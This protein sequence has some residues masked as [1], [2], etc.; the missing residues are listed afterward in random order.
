MG[1]IIAA[2]VLVAIAWAVAVRYEIA[3]PGGIRNQPARWTRFRSP[4]KG[5]PPDDAEPL[6][7]DDGG[8]LSYPGMRPDHPAVLLAG[9]ALLRVHPSEAPL[10]SWATGPGLGRPLDDVLA[11]A[12]AAPVSQRSAVLALGTGAAPGWLAEMLRN[13]GRRAAVPMVAAQAR[14]IVAG[15]SAHVG[16]GG[17]LPVTPVAGDGAVVSGW[18]ILPDTDELRMLDEA[19]PEYQRV[20]LPPRIQV[21]LTGGRVI[22]DCWAY[23]SR[24]GYLTD[25]SGRPRELTD[26]PALI[27][28]LLEDVPALSGIAGSSPEDWVRRAG[29]PAVRDRIR[30]ELTRSGLTGRGRELAGNGDA[31]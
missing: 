30:D 10:G 26:Q 2:I 1:W 15:V 5:A 16:T 31:G 22:Q 7:P 12:G 13:G 21:M 27:A 19:E 18:V 20:L 29:E 14:G 17:Y 11:Q 25:R 23:E 4:G 3:R 9:R 6:P 28:S 8:P 24:H